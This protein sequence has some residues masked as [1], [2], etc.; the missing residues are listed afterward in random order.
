[1]FLPLSFFAWFLCSRYLDRATRQ[2]GKILFS[3]STYRPDHTEFLRWSMWTSE[4]ISFSEGILMIFMRFARFFSFEIYWTCSG[5]DI[6]C[7]DS[8]MVEM[9]R[10][11]V[12]WKSV[13]IP[14]P[15]RAFDIPDMPDSLKTRTFV[16]CCEI[17]ILLL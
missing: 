7:F 17:L 15:N 6:S 2:D 10:A 5:G 14:V 13:Q 1:M 8:S 12:A 16:K 3:W 4:L 11:V 9:L